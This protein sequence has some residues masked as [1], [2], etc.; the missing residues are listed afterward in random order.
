[1]I[2]AFFVDFYGT[3]VH[4]DGEIIKKITE[5]IYDTGRVE[6]KPEIGAFWWNDFQ[7]M[8]T[9]SYGD[10]FETQRVLEEKSLVHTLAKFC[11]TANAKELS[12]YMFEHW[13]KPPIFE[14]SKDF[15]ASSPIPIY[16]VSNIDTADILKAIEYHDLTPTGVFTSED[17]RAYK[18]RTELFELALRS[19]GLKTDE[20]IHIGDSISSDVKGAS[21]VNIRALWLNRFGKEIPE[22]VECITDLLGAL[23]KIM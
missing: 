20:V 23:D 17:A 1:M 2:K 7:S 8:F 14:E 3:V 13:I 18:P 10:S 11:S 6:N 5:I 19:T 15:F 16:I 9:N 4:E 12:N 21:S 22:G